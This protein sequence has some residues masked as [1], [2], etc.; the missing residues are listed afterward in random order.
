MAIPPEQI[1]VQK[2]LL[3]LKPGGSY[4]AL[5]IPERSKLPYG[6]AFG[7]SLSVGTSMP[8]REEK[9]HKPK[10]PKKSWNPGEM[11]EK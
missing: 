5:S 11:S 2:V 6:S 8:T 4:P 7:S 3:R 10:P 9:R 1:V